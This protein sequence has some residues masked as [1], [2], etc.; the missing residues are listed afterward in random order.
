MFHS[1]L[2]QIL[3]CFFFSAPVVSFSKPSLLIHNGV[4]AY[5]PNSWETDFTHK[6]S[7]CKSFICRKPFVTQQNLVNGTK[8]RLCFQ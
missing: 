4:T 3:E 8:T 5:N 7:I 2:A 1:L 6:M